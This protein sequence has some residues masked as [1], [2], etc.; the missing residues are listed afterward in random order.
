LTLPAVFVKRDFPQ[1]F[2]GLQLAAAAIVGLDP[3]LLAFEVDD[4]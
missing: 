1:P 2:A 4:A 3:G